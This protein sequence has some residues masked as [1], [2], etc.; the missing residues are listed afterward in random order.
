MKAKKIF[1]VLVIAMFMA[2]CSSDDETY[3]S[4]S[5]QP[6]VSCSSSISGTTDGVSALSQAYTS[7]FEAN[8]FSVSYMF[9]SIMLVPKTYSAENVLVEDSAKTRQSFVEQAKKEYTDYMKI[10][11]ETNLA[12]TQPSLQNFVAQGRLQVNLVIDDLTISI[13]DSTTVPSL[14]ETTWTTTNEL[15][16]LKKIVFKSENVFDLYGEGNNVISEGL[17]YYRLGGNVRRSENPKLALNFINVETLNLSIYEDSFSEPI[18][19]VK[20]GN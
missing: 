17:S 14:A 13:K 18:F 16:P 19:F 3:T 1:Q 5:Y 9:S 2:S 4:V 15:S 8:G 20:S 6:E 10:I 12:K 11:S 7:L